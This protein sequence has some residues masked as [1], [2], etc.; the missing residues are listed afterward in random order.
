M[1]KISILMA[2]YD[3][4][5]YLVKRAI[6]S[7]LNQDFQDF[8]MIIIDDGSQNGTQNQLLEYVIRN[9]IKISYLRHINCGQSESINR[10]IL[11]S[12][13]DYITFLDADDE[14]RPDHLSSCLKAIGSLDLIAS[15]T[16][17]IVDCLDDYYV[18]DKYDQ[19]LLVHVDDCILF[20]TLFGKKDVFMNLKFQKKYA[21]DAQFYETASERF[22]VNKVNLRTYVYYRNIPNSTCAKIKNETLTSLTNNHL[23]GAFVKK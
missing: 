9:Q 7:V 19:S 18:P 10:G 2:V 3:T 23:Y 21:A 15:T 4:D 1:P 5:F 8:E 13:G 16:E 6:D 11:N 17:T 22:T 20:A 14:Y 12:T